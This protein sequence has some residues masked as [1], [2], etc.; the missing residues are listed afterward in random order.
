M[1]IS[2]SDSELAAVMKAA[3]PIP[4]RDRSD[5][6]RDVVAELQKYPEIGPGIIGRVCAKMQRAHL[7]PPSFRNNIG[8]KWR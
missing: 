2:L 5:F 6:L 7:N 1:P 3:K 4:S 8:G